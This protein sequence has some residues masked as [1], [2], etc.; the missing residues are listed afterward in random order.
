M[1]A[2]TPETDQRRK[3]YPDRKTV[4]QQS[5]RDIN[6]QLRQNKDFQA[7]SHQIIYIQPK[8]L[9]QEHQE[10]QKRARQKGTY[11]TAKNKQIQTLKHRAKLRINRK[12]T[13]APSV[14][15]K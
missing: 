4:R 6:N 9:K 5:G 2:H 10:H 8:K 3:K 15:F 12:N 11:K 13:K 7:F 1:L 14:L